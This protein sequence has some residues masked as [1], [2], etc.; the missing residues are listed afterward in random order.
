MGETNCKAMES[1]RERKRIL[2]RESESVC[3]RVAKR[4]VGMRE[5]R[6]RD[7]EPP[8]SK[9]LFPHTL[10]MGVEIIRGKPWANHHIAQTSPHTLSIA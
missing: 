1:F 5:K 10:S 6:E 8:A 7:S 3:D 4:N 2:E 9:S